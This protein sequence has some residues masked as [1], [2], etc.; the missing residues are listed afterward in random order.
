M[1]RPR[2]SLLSLSR[3]LLALSILLAF[4]F[5][6]LGNLHLMRERNIDALRAIR[7]S[8]FLLEPASRKNYT[9]G[10]ILYTRNHAVESLQAVWE[11]RKRNPQAYYPESTIVQEMPQSN[12]TTGEDGDVTLVTCATVEQLLQLVHVSKRWTGP[13]AVATFISN[14]TELDVFMQFH[15]Q[16]NASLPNVSFHFLVDYTQSINNPPSSPYPVG[17]L[18][19]L[20]IQNSRTEFL[21]VMDLDFLPCQD[22]YPQMVHLLQME[23]EVRATVDDTTLLVLPSYERTSAKQSLTS[24][25]EASTNHTTLIH[26][27]RRSTSQPH[28][29]HRLR[30]RSMDMIIY[31][32]WKTK[33]PGWIY[34][35]PFEYGMEPTVLASKRGLA[36]FP[37]QFTDPWFARSAWIEACDAQGFKLAVLRKLFVY[38]TLEPTRLAAHEPSNNQDYREFRKGLPNRYER[39]FGVPTISNVH[40]V[41]A[42]VMCTGTEGAIIRNV[43]D[44]LQKKL[45]CAFQQFV[46][47]R[48]RRRQIPFAFYG[49]NALVPKL[50]NP[51]SDDDIT[52][53]LQ[54]SVDRMDRIVEGAKRWTAPMSVAV[55]ANSTESIQQAV[56]FFY[57]HA[58]ALVNASFHLFFE[59]IITEK[60][61]FYPHNFMRNCALNFT[62]TEYVILLDADFTLSQGAHT[63]LVNLVQGNGEIRQKLQN[64]TLMVL[65][66]FERIVQEENR[67]P[68][69]LPPPTKE[70]LRIQVR[71]NM[72][73]PFHMKKFKVGH[74]ATN[75]LRWFLNESA[76]YYDI[77]YER[78][79]EPYVLARRRDLHWF[80]TGF[81]GFG[82]NKISWYEESHTFGFQYAVL[83]DFFCYHEGQ[84]S[85]T[86]RAPWWVSFERRIFE[87]YLQLKARDLGDEATLERAKFF[88]NHTESSANLGNIR[89]GD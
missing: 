21:L 9:T 55:Y 34:P 44:P 50:R 29:M 37:E 10:K 11:N 7:D 79:F 59:K 28:A 88:L 54:C 13:I 87:T 80:W 85:T 3:I 77:E 82:V 39:A 53:A 42:S 66:A 4:I 76:P 8:Y 56:Q 22:M 14:Q 43:S 74:G 26:S 20:A 27:L 23:R 36:M 64:R 31:R 68:P 60:D 75:Y 25:W 57:A 1:A 19:N 71:K 24:L 63:G 61:T 45:H 35:C 70:V 2:R 89:P 46:S 65:P 6:L 78:S 81:R 47:S 69:P 58:D 73:A 41:S 86:K 62:R 83:R 72:S 30:G 15:Q 18:M 17:K 16:R 52:L 33:R 40:Q 12:P 48:D 38:R 51:L 67:R 84:S 32:Q 5:M 49:D